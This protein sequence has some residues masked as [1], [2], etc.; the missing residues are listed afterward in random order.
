[1]NKNALSNRNMG[2]DLLK[3][4]STFLVVLLHLLGAGGI[5]SSCEPLS[6]NYNAA[7]LLE[8]FAYNSV[9]IF[10]I[11]TGYVYARTQNHR[12]GK[13]FDL[14]G[15][16]F[17]Y[18]IIFAAVFFLSG[19]IVLAEA[20][21]NSLPV[22]NKNHW[23]FSAYICLWM[24]IPYINKMLHA[25]TK[26][27]HFTLIAIGFCLFCIYFFAYEFL[28]TDIFVLKRG[29]S[30]LWLFYVYCVGAY[31][32]LHADGL[33]KAKKRTCLLVF[34]GCTVFAWGL[35][36]LL[37]FIGTDLTTRISDMVVSYPSPLIV[38]ASI[39]FFVLFINLKIKSNKFIFTVSA[40]SFF[41]YILHT[42]PLFYF[43]ILSGSLSSLTDQPWYILIASVLG[44]AVAVYIVCTVIDVI[45][46][47]VFRLIHIEKFYNLIVKLLHTC[48]DKVRNYLLEKI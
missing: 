46:Q 16:V 37:L 1:M 28:K 12:W 42:N 34:V 38:F 2:L 26:K 18:S 9:N 48:F 23:Y 40:S 4:L 15:A 5:L 7:W 6:D 31:I 27:Q 43:K 35:K 3:I 36:L 41:V 47:K 44:I 39:A 33:K 29:Y 21:Y 30:P 13:L 22:T 8:T 10:C 24:I 32:S 45:R 19:K 14:W 17:F 25:M 20:F 11:T